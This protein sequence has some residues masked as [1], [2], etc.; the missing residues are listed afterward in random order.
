MS[1]QL[2]DLNF[3]I[4]IKRIEHF[5]MI[6]GGVY[7]DQRPDDEFKRRFTS[8]IHQ[9]NFL[10]SDHIHKDLL[11]L[12]DGSIVLLNENQVIVYDENI[13]NPKLLVNADCLN[14]RPHCITY[15]SQHQ[16]MY[17]AGYDCIIK[18]NMKFDITA[19]FN[20]KKDESFISSIYF[21]HN[22]VF[23]CDF[24]RR[25]I[26]LLTADKLEYI[27]SLELYYKPVQIIVNYSTICIRSGDFNSVHFYDLKTFR[28]K[29]RYYGHC[30]FISIIDS[31]FCEFDV[32]NAKFYFY[33]SEGVKDDEEIENGFF[34][35]IQNDAK[36]I[37]EKC[38][39]NGK[40]I[41]LQDSLLIL[42]RQKN[43]KTLLLRLFDA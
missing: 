38:L 33:N 43:D 39:I 11:L 3:N 22:T 29:S 35:I 13:E 17:M 41:N 20:F 27:H 42:L 10:K 15:D 5:K 21:Q 36:T 1:G 12:R 25:R 34:K 18:A 31:F 30:G 2:I 14:V 37:A 6:Y 4:D 8:R 16:N 28:L 32:L 19:R 26:L 23:A 7:Y 24:K 9:I 40:I